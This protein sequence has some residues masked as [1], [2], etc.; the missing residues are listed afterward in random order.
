[1]VVGISPPSA[2]RRTHP[3]RP[4]SPP[5]RGRRMH[6]YSR[7]YTEKVSARAVR[8][9]PFQLPPAPARSDLVSKYF[10]TLADPTR[11]RILQLLA[12]EGELSVSEIASRLDIA[13]A[14]ISN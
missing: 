13:I 8:Q 3:G 14:G 6:H 4:S 9:A 7:A 1:M 11:L 5:D 2:Q 10:R 12:S